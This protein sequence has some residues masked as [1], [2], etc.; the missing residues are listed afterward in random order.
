MCLVGTALA[1]LPQ[2]QSLSVS[3]AYATLA[4]STNTPQTSASPPS[5]QPAPQKRAQHPSRKVK[6]P[7]SAK[8]SGRSSAKKGAAK[9]RTR[10]LGAFAV[11]AYTY[12]W[13]DNIMTRT[14]SG[15]F[16]MVGR[17]V[18]V[19]PRVIPL[20]STIY[21]EGLGERIAEDS[22]KRVKGN[23]L[24]LFLP[25]DYLC[26]QFGVRQHNVQIVEK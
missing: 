26:R 22:G 8:T 21:I 17:T 1:N 19:D 5:T 11:R 15:T 13:D 23:V 24:D 16:P 2:T 12:E 18:A 6:S 25:S 20:G 14:A 10:H 9:R 3:T 4:V 7:L